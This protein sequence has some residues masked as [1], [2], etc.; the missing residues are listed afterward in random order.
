M[1]DMVSPGVLSAHSVTFDFTFS[2]VHS[3]LL[4]GFAQGREDQ[5]ELRH[6]ADRQ[7]QERVSGRLELLEE[8]ILDSL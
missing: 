5:A 8:K 7:R 4:Q 1:S 6:R 2:C 3:H